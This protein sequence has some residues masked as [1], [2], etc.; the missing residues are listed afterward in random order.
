MPLVSEGEQ[1]RSLELSRNTAQRYKARTPSPLRVSTDCSSAEEHDTNHRP[2]VTPDPTKSEALSA[3]K[4][5]KNPLNPSPEAKTS[6][7]GWS[8]TTEQVGGE[9]RRE[10]IATCFGRS[11]EESPKSHGSDRTRWADSMLDWDNFYKH[12]SEEGELLEAP[13]SC[14]PVLRL[15]PSQPSQE[16]HE[17]HVKPSAQQISIE[18]QNGVTNTAQQG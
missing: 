1:K 13:L 15:T 16:E 4:D 3:P 18:K 2:T 6:G 5:G 12:F 10:Q 7:S 17:E 14:L 11:R 8:G 9:H